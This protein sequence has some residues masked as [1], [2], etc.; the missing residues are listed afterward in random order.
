LRQTL[1]ATT[2]FVG[3][4]PE[5]NSGIGTAEKGVDVFGFAGG[6][7]EQFAC[8]G[9]SR[10]GEG[11][12]GCDIMQEGLDNVNGLQKMALVCAGVEVST[13]E[14]GTR[15]FPRQWGRGELGKSMEGGLR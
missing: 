2:P 15:T 6:G 3:E 11:G 14:P 7:M 5:P 13:R 12:V 4:R 9:D 8:E 10:G 1:H